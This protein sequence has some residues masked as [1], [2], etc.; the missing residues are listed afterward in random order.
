MAGIDWLGHESPDVIMLVRGEYST[1]AGVLQRVRWCGPS[2]RIRSAVYAYDPD[3]TSPTRTKS[4]WEARLSGNKVDATLGRLNQSVQAVSDMD[5]AVDIGNYD[6]EA[7]ETADLDD[8]A[9]AASILTGRW[10]NH[11]VRVWLYDRNDGSAQ[12]VFRGRWNREPTAMSIGRFTMRA[13]MA[14]FPLDEEFSLD[15]F[16]AGETNPVAWSDSSSVTGITEWW[17]IQYF[18]HPD[19]WGKKPGIIVGD[20][21]LET[22]YVWREAIPYGT[23]TIS[24]VFYAYAWV[25]GLA[26][27]FVHDVWYEGNDGTIV[28][29]ANVNTAEQDRPDRGPEGTIVRFTYGLAGQAPLEFM[30]LGQP[31]GRVWVRCSGLVTGQMPGPIT[32]ANWYSHTGYARHAIWEVLED[33]VEHPQLLD[34][35]G[36]FG[37]NALAA[38]QAGCPSTE[39]DFRRGLCALPRE[40]ETETPSARELLG[41]ILSSLPADLCYRWDSAAEETRVYPLWRPKVGSLPTWTLNRYDFA[42]PAFPEFRSQDDPDGVYGTRVNVKSTPYWSTPLG[43][44]EYQI[45]V[46][47]SRTLNVLILADDGPFGLFRGTRTKKIEQDVWRFNG[48]DGFEE[49]VR[50]I[51]NERGQK[52]IVIEATLGIRGYAIQMGDSVKY[53]IPGVWS[54]LGQVRALHYDFDSMT[55]KVRSYHID[56]YSS[57]DAGDHQQGD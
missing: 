57:A 5:F 18:A 34:A 37:T 53:D 23:R 8:A 3:D 32:G 15:E 43:S 14:L 29:A 33:I 19:H 42:N 41:G 46:E 30:T 26:N 39:A 12:E 50:F 27:H 17:P 13:E 4:P 36:V 9:L 55:V 10:A 1:P 54:G 25:S 49:A 20:A 47:I 28:N 44:P 2:G 11:A 56:F 35:P 40:V 52:Q 48:D 24:G 51:A 7:S 45:D 21:S 16:P 22:A 38:F 31:P 6:S